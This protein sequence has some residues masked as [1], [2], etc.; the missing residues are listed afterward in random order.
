M[1]EEDEEVPREYLFV[2][3][4]FSAGFDSFFLSL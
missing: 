1:A 3:S 2:G 4:S